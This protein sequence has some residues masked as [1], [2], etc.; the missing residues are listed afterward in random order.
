MYLSLEQA[1]HKMT[2]MPADV[3]GAMQCLNWFGEYGY[4]GPGSQ[5]NTYE[6]ILYALDVE[7]L[8][9]V[10]SESQLAQIKTALDTHAIETA[11]LSGQ[12][13]GPP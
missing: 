7:T 11:T 10:D 13:E 3:P 1:I 8:P 6:F 2:A 12:T 9:G 5:D 4:G